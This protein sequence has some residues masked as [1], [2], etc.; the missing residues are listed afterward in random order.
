M[1]QKSR[2]EIH[3]LSKDHIPLISYLENAM[4]ENKIEYAI[5]IDRAK[6][7]RKYPYI[8]VNGSVKCVK[9]VIL[10]KRDGHLK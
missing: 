10:M 4:K 8:T 3:L 5:M 9:R 7:C 6:L 1:T 2:V